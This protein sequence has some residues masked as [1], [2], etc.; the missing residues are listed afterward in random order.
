M[1]CVS[2]LAASL[3]VLVA[4]CTSSSGDTA[5]SAGSQPR[6]TTT[7]P[8]VTT[9]TVPVTTTTEAP[10]GYGGEV[11]IGVDF[12][13]ETLNPFAPNAFGVDMYSNLVWATVYDID[14]DTWDRMPDVVEAMPSA[15]D[16]IIV[17]DDGTMTVTYKIVDEATWSDG[18]PIAGVDVAFTA[19]AMRDMAI[20]CEGNVDPVMAT[21]VGTESD[22]KSA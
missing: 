12:P 22:G 6:A 10:D 7:V 1:G 9:T 5:T 18:E 13:I 14:P 11:K 4:A 16:G 2:I 15:S 8:A 19:A 3:V 17:N 20:A 21:V